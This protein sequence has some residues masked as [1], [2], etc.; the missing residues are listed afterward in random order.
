VYSLESALA[1]VVTYHGACSLVGGLEYAE[2]AISKLDGTPVGLD[3][4]KH[5]SDTVKSMNGK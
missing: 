2:G 3:P 5:V 1:D 4:L